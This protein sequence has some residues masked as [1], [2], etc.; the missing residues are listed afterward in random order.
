MKVDESGGGKSALQKLL[1]RFEQADSARAKSVGKKEDLNDN[2]STKKPMGQRSKNPIVT[3]DAHS[4]EVVR[5]SSRGDD[6]NSN[7]DNNDGG[8]AE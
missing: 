8:G 1:L 3:A 7:T 6:K 4:T 2:N 5:S